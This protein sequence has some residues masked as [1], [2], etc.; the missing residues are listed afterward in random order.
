MNLFLDTISPKNTLLLFNDKKEIINI[1][2]FDV[3]LNESTKLIEELDNFLKL[4]DM[5]YF[6]LE[7]IVVVNWPWSFTWVRTTILLINT[8]NFIIKKNI[9]TITYFDLFDNNYP[10]IKSSSK[11][12]SFV[13]LSKSDEI[14][15]IENDKIANLLIENNATKVYS[16]TSFLENIEIIK[17]VDYK[18][19]IKN[20]ELSKNSIVSPFYFKKPN[21]S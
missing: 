8:I 16:D 5:N 3:R 17:D 13:K 9:S 21:I 4:N 11:R 19:I 2:H 20:L 1:Y 10:I 18:N 7:N 15:V 14:V 12:D 6:N